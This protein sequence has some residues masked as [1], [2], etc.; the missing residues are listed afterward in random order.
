MSRY[1]TLRR[2][3][4]ATFVYFGLTDSCKQI[5]CIKLGAESNNR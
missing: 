1:A 5:A 3:D 2:C 4:F